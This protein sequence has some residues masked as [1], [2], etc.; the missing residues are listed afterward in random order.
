V[1]EDHRRRSAR[2]GAAIS[3]SAKFPTRAQRI[4][5]DVSRSLTLTRLAL[6]IPLVVF[7]RV[8]ASGITVAIL[9]AIGFVSD[10][11]DGVIARRFGVVTE[12]LRRL[13]SA[14]D[15]VFYLAAM[16]CA[17]RLHESTIL[18]NRWLVVGVV[19]TLVLN[20]LVEFIKF[21]RESSYHA[22]LAKTWGIVLFVALVF[23]FAGNNDA[24]IPWALGFGLLSHAENLAI[25]LAL[26]VWQHDVP[27]IFH[28]VSIRR[29]R[30]RKRQVELP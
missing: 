12:G 7:G 27:T 14:A 20:H 10:I 9:I 30:S 19:G 26:P 25:T 15:T 28:A 3:R 4:A 8:R 11:Y 16:F 29:A 22:W 21:R 1:G 13:D 23:L 24:L 5:Y 17:W 6:A 2:G 18:A